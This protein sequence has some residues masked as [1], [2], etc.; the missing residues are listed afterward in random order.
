MNIKDVKN[1]NVKHKQWTQYFP[2]IP[3]KADLQTSFPPTTVKLSNP[4]CTWREIVCR[5]SQV[6]GLYGV[7]HREDGQKCM[8]VNVG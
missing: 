8:K 6:V 2:P 7:K 5:D 1:Y 3:D 4:T